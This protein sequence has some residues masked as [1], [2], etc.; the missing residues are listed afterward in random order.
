MRRAKVDQLCADLGLTRFQVLLGV[1]S[2]SLYGATGLLRP[3]IAAPV[4]NRPVREFQDSVGMMANTVLLPV[5]VTPGEDLRSQLARTGAESG[6][7]LQR[8]DV[9]LAD[10]LTDW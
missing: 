3:R 1:F 7:V 8:Q 4:A 9:A 10:V 2:W 6:Q 5:T